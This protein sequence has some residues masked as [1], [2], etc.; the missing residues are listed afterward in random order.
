MIKRGLYDN[1]DKKCIQISRDTDFSA[2]AYFSFLAFPASA[3]FS[4]RYFQT[5]LPHAIEVSRLHEFFKGIAAN[6][7]TGI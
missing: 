7:D 6:N 3:N 4:T 5:E 1:N 2:P